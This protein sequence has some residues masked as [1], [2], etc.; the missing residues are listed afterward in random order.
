MNNKNLR[1]ILVTYFLLIYGLGSVV[2]IYYD[3]FIDTSNSTHDGGYYLYALIIYVPFPLFL[4]ALVNLLIIRES[5]NHIKAMLVVKIAFPFICLIL[6][7]AQFYILSMVESSQ[8]VCLSISI[9]LF[10]ASIFSLLTN[11]RHIK[12]R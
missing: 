7:P 11:L 3:I 10:C 1:L 9:I 2:K 5:K 12:N 6:T 4:A 8:M